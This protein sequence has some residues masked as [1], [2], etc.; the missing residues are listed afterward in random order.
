MWELFLF[1]FVAWMLRSW[2]HMPGFATFALF[3]LADACFIV[4]IRAT[5]PERTE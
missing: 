5:D 3:L 1:F 4:A 2:Q